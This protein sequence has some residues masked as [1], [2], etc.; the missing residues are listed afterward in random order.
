M[1]Y[2]NLISLM[3]K[4]PAVDPDA[5]A[6]IT[7]AGITNATQKTAVNQLVLNLKSYSLWTKMNAIY[8][9][10]GG[11]SSSHAVN[12]KSPGTYN[13]SFSSGWTHTSLGMTPSGAYADTNLNSDTGVVILQ[14][15]AHIS[16][17]SRTNSVNNYQMDMGAKDNLYLS[18]KYGTGYGIINNLNVSGFGGD[19]TNTDS[20]GFYLSTR[21]A[22][23]VTKVFQN[24]TLKR[25]DTRSSSTFVSQGNITIGRYNAGGL[26][27]TN[28]QYAFASIGSGLTDTDAAN[29]YTAVQ[30][31]QTTL[32]R[33]V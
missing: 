16:F 27:Y 25:T 6:F 13:L 31:Y 15:S 7:A 4:T 11:T 21:T 18:A 3:P 33:Q 28:R 23:N 17:Y 32:S 2:Y 24:N 30:A 14:N 22:S 9:I 29:F 10:V 20:R 8:P 26:D 1:S 5:Q 19:I 12:L